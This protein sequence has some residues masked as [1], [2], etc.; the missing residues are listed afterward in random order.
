MGKIAIHLKFHWN[1]KTN[2]PV[3]PRRPI[4]SQD[5]NLASHLKDHIYKR[6]AHFYE[7]GTVA[8]LKL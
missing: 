4:Y 6:S 8:N 5:I 1:A 3:F 2:I 7:S